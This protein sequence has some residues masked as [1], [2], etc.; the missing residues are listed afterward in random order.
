MGFHP[1]RLVTVII[2]CYNHARFLGEAIQSVLEQTY[3]PVEIVVVDDGSSDDTVGVAGRYPVR[4]VRQANQGLAAARNTGVRESGGEYLVFL[5]ADD[6]LLPEAI[7]IGTRELETHPDCAFVAGRYRIIA[8]DGSAV[9]VPPPADLGSDHY[10]D[11]LARNHIGHCGTVMYRRHVVD[12]LGGFDTAWRAGED[13][14]LYLRVAR[15]FPVTYHRHVI[16][17]YR[18]YPTAMSKNARLMLRSVLG[19][20]H[21]Q[22]RYIR[23]RADYEEAYTQGIRFYQTRYGE[24]LVEEVRANVRSHCWRDA[25]RGAVVLA[26]Y[27]PHAFATHAL[28]KAYSAV[29]ARAGA[30][31]G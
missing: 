13:Y 7:D 1:R 27:H 11:L 24:R 6:R 29:V 28:R 9:S 18:R 26:R 12:T 30:F 4:Y 19:V 20:L 15:R 31:R 22:R 10:R 25:I 14:D 8:V 3:R 21:A 5:D 16:A 17:E 23:G 2:P